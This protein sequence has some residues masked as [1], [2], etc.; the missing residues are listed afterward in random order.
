MNGPLKVLFVSAEVAPFAKVGGLADVAGALPAALAARGHDVRVVTPRHSAEAIGEV[1]AS[2]FL[3]G[4]REAAARSTTS[5]G[6]GVAVYLVESEGLFPRDR[7]YGEANDLE[8]Y[9]AFCQA[10]L[11]L[12]KQLGWRPDVFHCNDWHTAP[13]GFGVRNRAWGDG[14]Y[15]GAACVLTIHNLR[16]RGPD[17]LAD[18]LCQ[19]IYYADAVT[20][21]S[22][23][24]AR[25]ILTPEYGE[26]LHP[27]LQERQDRLFGILNGLDYR[28]YDPAGDPHLASNFEAA[29]LERRSA[30]KAALQERAGLAPDANAP[31]VGMVSR[32]TEQ[33]G[34]DLTLEA[35]GALLS[36]GAAQFVVLGTGDEAYHRAFRDLA[37][38]H[39]G[40]A[41]VS[42]AFDHPLAQ[43]IY[44]GCDMFLMPS[45]F[46]PCG[47]GQLIALRYGAIPVVRHTGGLADTVF[48]YAGP[49]GEGNGFVFHE[50][51]AAALLAALRR[52]LAT[53]QHSDEWRRLQ[54]RGMGLD[55]SWDRSAERYEG[56]YRRAMAGGGSA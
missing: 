36:E 31:V 42:I 23:T 43:L 30:N 39:V 6:E 17:E 24:Y 38:Q 10:A 40:R 8:R 51:S 13:I 12:P 37:Q 9:L 1:A 55:F 21:V 26:G 41:A 53:F 54:T 16:Y 49:E 29:T 22:E 46:E 48:D 19:G 11:E 50:Y 20:T 56:V 44:G 35:M 32:L 4:G 15:R 28:Q 14:F 7:V 52:A 25:E 34:M 47:L 27:L 5:G 45:R 33:K 2:V 18:F 3:S